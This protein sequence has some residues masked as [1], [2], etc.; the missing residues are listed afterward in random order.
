M[1]DAKSFE[2]KMKMLEEIVE[3]LEDRNISLN[4]A[5]DNFEKGVKLVKDLNSELEEAEG[6]IKILTKELTLTDA[7]KTE[8]L[9]NEN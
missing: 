3:K 4:S 6:K 7:D 5:L 9:D 1:S 2:E 8:F